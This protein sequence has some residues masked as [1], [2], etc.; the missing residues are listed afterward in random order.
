MLISVFG[1]WINP[2]Q[3]VRI[4]RNT[5]YFTGGKDSLSF[6]SA[7]S[8]ELAAVVNAAEYDLDGHITQIIR[9]SH[10]AI[11]LAARLTDENKLLKAELEGLRVLNNVT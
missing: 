9:N 10:D 8:N 4:Q 5:I 2:T 1:Q 7:T 6:S 11:K 3:I